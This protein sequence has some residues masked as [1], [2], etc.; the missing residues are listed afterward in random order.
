MKRAAQM[1]KDNAG[2]VIEG[3]NKSFGGVHAADDVSLVLGPH[4]MLCLVGPNGCGKT[5]L[6]N[7]ITGFLRPDSGSIRFCETDLA[8]G[9]PVSIARAG[10]ARKFQVPSVFADLTAFDN[11]RVAC[12]APSVT[13]AKRSEEN[14]A[15]REAMSGTVMAWLAKV[16]LGDVADLP[17]Q[18]LSHGQK[19]WLEVAMVLACRPGL[20]LLD[21]PTAGMTRAETLASVE[22][23][24][25]LHRTSGTAMILIEHDMGFVEALGCPVAVMLQGRIV[26]RGPFADVSELPQVREAYLGTAHA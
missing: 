24:A 13:R 3:L 14:A 20:M 18:H 22:L 12:N 25:E 16:G 1:E 21:E 19:Q 15:S 23:I 4:E 8:K 17:A 9:D 2:L 7:M 11:V 6:F 10:I 5:T 26:A